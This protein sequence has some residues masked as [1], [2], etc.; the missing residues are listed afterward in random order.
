MCRS[1][2]CY[3]RSSYNGIH[4]PM[5]IAG[6]V[7]SAELRVRS[8]NFHCGKI[9]RGNDRISN[10]WHNYYVSAT[11]GDDGNSGTDSSHPWKTLDKANAIA[12]QLKPGDAILLER[13]SIFD[14]QSLRIENTTGSE[15]A[16]ITIGAYG[17]TGAPKPIVSANGAPS[18]HWEQNYRGYVGNHKN[19]GT[20]S[21]AVL[22]R[23]VSHIV[24]K[25]LEI[26]NDD[27]DV[28]DPIATWKWTDQADADGT[29]LDRRASRMG[30]TGVA[31]IAEMVQR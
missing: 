27:P 24:V 10:F 22:L 3:N 18:S 7:H 8:G 31:G 23:D 15:Q 12:P 4:V 26:T 5:H 1:G 14:N 30:R 19:H 21:S 13:G 28:N 20:V 29:H 2:R 17:D 25:D 9:N 16:P 6:W 11:H